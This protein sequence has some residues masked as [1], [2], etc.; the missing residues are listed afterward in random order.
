MTDVTHDKQGRPL[1]S[2]P[3]AAALKE[4]FF[5]AVCLMERLR[6]DCPWDREQTEE[7][8]APH[9]LEEA[10]EALGGDG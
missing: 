9:L 8:M 7:S 3:K 4:S 1:F 2:E 6:S 5:R 10:Y